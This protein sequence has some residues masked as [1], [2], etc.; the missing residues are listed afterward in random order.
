MPVNHLP[1]LLHQLD[2]IYHLNNWTIEELSLETLSS[3]PRIVRPDHLLGGY[4]S[5]CLE[6]PK[7]LNSHNS[8]AAFD[9]IVFETNPKAKW[10]EGP[11]NAYHYVIRRSGREDYPYLLSGP[12]NAGTLIGHHPKSLNLDPYTRHSTSTI[13]QASDLRSSLGE[14]VKNPPISSQ[15]D[16]LQL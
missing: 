11:I 9:V 5:G 4:I 16:T 1:L 8:I 12:Y 15:L 14:S 6:R 2:S 7:L 10:D 13:Y 3:I